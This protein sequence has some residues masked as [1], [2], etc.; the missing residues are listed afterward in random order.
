MEPFIKTIRERVDHD[1]E[2]FLMGLSD[3]YERINPQEI[4]ADTFVH[5]DA[6]FENALYS[7]DSPAIILLC[8][9]K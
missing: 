8:T 4:R 5:G 7:A 3:L 2:S 1:I 6:H 9:T